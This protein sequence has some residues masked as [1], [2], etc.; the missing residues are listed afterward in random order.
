MAWQDD[1]EAKIKNNE[2]KEALE[3]LRTSVGR[4]AAQAADRIIALRDILGRPGITAEQAARFFTENNLTA[5]DRAKTLEPPL[6]QDK[7]LAIFKANKSFQTTFLPEILAS[8]ITPGRAAEYIDET[9]PNN[10]QC[11][12]LLETLATSKP[13]RA[14]E[15][16][17]A[18]NKPR[19]AAVLSS[20]PT[21]TR[22]AFTTGMDAQ[23]LATVRGLQTRLHD[24]FERSLGTADA[25]E[26]AAMFNSTVRAPR[27]YGP[28]GILT[29]VVTGPA[30]LSPSHQQTFKKLDAEKRFGILE[31]F[32]GNRIASSRL[33]SSLSRGERVA[34]LAAAYTQ[35][36]A[37]GLDP[38]RAG[39]IRAHANQLY[40]SEPNG[41]ERTRLLWNKANFA[42]PEMRGAFFTGLEAK[43]QAAR[44]NEMRDSWWLPRPDRVFYEGLDDKSKTELFTKMT[45]GQWVGDA[46]AAQ[47]HAI[48]L[49]THGSRESGAR[50]AVIKGLLA[51]KDD[52]SLQLAAALI[53]APEPGLTTSS[54]NAHREIFEKIDDPAQ[55]GV[56]FNRMMGGGEDKAAQEVKFD[57]DLYQQGLRLLAS[58]RLTE[59]QKQQMFNG[60]TMKDGTPNTRLQALM[61]GEGGETLGNRGP[62]A[63]TAQGLFMGCL[64]TLDTVE[65]RGK[66]AADMIGSLNDQRSYVVSDSLRTTMFK[67]L[68]TQVKMQAFLA[69]ANQPAQ[70]ALADEFQR[71]S[72]ENQQLVLDQLRVERAAASADQ[73]KVQAIDGVEKQLF[74]AL[75]TPSYSTT[76]PQVAYLNRVQQ[77]AA[78]PQEGL[79]AQQR[80]LDGL[81]AK[82]LAVVFN[83]SRVSGKMESPNREQNFAH[84]VESKD[85]YVRAAAILSEGSGVMSAGH[86]L[87]KDYAG[88]AVSGP[89][90][91]YKI[92]SPDK[93]KHLVQVF[94][95]LDKSSPKEARN[96]FK[97][98]PPQVR[99]ALS[100][101]QTF[102]AKCHHALGK[103]K[104]GMAN[105]QA[106]QAQQPVQQGG[107]GPSPPP[108]K[109]P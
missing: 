60:L 94:V 3:L 51:K 92:I 45:S 36:N 28:G 87:L 70:K 38:N 57:S 66:Y 109:G 21:Q 15:I 59:E 55:R 25:K 34:T 37:Q 23:A 106:P 27:S 39:E 67:N 102:K 2:H 46:K 103:P 82:Q 104:P 26:A 75:K 20:L 4:D 76:N 53:R 86:N 88:S 30:Y 85:G 41:K 14:R 16:F 83:T 108:Q 65:K 18:L 89:V 95:E 11:A 56:L 58:R 31:E 97:A 107:G 74:A 24:T 68:D 13:D 32:K 78:T 80:L 63:A 35:A 105:V 50:A 40:L 33:W 61:L 6:D 62:D 91:N 19:M 10:A 7:A 96:Y 72:F 5:L 47:A 43:E 17:Q 93:F 99:E 101:D 49:F 54:Y 71:D 73:A 100:Q 29:E 12:K 81:D 90:V 64:A 9:N 98:L 1:V 77:L 48:D 69:A 22:N 52:P 44:L 8:G 42:S 79:A 84:V